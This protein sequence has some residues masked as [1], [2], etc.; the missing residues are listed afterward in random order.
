MFGMATVLA[1]DVAAGDDTEIGSEVTIASLTILFTTM[2]A[3]GECDAMIADIQT[4]IRDRVVA[5]KQAATTTQPASKSPARKSKPKQEVGTHRL[6]AGA[7]LKGAV[8]V[9]VAIEGDKT[10]FRLT[11]PIGD[12][13]SGATLRVPSKIVR[14]IVEPPY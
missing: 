5:V 2:I 14:P 11:E 7:G 9:V 4:A 12:R 1:E 10:T 13:K 3:S 8:G 6:I